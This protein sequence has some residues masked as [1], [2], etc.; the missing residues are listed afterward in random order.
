MADEAV[1]GRVSDS[2]RNLA[3][4]NYGLLFASIFFAGVPALI[5]AIIAYSQ[6]DEAPPTVRSHYKFQIRIFWIAFGMALAAG[7]SFLGV[8]VRVTSEVF[9]FTQIPGWD[10]HDNV[11]LDLSNITVDGTLMALLVSSALFSALGGVW[12][13]LAPGLGFVR[14]ASARG[15]GHSARS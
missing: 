4:I 8:V 2:A 14:L 13:I 3:F 1:G 11:K 7:L 10:V 5:A 12:L 9:Q 15:M 6:Q